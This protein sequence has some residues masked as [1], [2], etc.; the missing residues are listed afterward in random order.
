M[1]NLKKYNTIHYGNVNIL[2][3]GVKAFFSTL[4]PQ[5]DVWLLFNNE[6]DFRECCLDFVFS[7][8]CVYDNGN[9]FILKKPT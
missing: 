1:K 6:P 9:I 4:S 2:F 3:P 5:I 7:N 8:S